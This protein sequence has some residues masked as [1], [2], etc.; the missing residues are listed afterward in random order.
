M[1]LKPYK[2]QTSVTSWLIKQ[3][4]EKAEFGPDGQ[5]RFRRHIA[6]VYALKKLIIKSGG[7]E[8]DLRKQLKWRLKYA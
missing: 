1:S 5:D 8:K 4:R 7:S 6:E 2:K 3:A